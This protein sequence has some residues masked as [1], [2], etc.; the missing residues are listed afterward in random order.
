VLWC[1]LRQQQEKL[2]DHVP[3]SRRAILY[4]EF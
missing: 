1:H 3:R 4:F 2:R